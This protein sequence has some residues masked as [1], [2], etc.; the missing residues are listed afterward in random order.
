MYWCWG[1]ITEEIRDCCILL[2]RCAPSNHLHMPH[3]HCHWLALLTNASHTSLLNLGL[4]DIFLLFHAISRNKRMTN[5]M[6][7]SAHIIICWIILSINTPFLDVV[8][9]NQFKS[10]PIMLYEI[11]CWPIFSL[12]FV[13][14][15]LVIIVR[16]EFAKL[17]LK[18]LLEI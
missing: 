10:W 3:F 12:T 13:L 18:L 6:S 7:F 9:H 5:W 11:A 1:L 2:I 16:A 15:Q 8:L 14:G 4:S 17:G